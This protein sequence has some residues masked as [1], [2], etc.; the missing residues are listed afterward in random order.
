V[1]T[2]VVDLALPVALY[3]ALRAGGVDQLAALLVGGA[4]PA[5]RVAWV[6]A[7]TRHLDTIGAL[8]LAA[9]VLAVVS[10]LIEGDPRTLLVRNALLGFPFAVWMLASLAASRPLTYLSAKALLPSKER[11]FERVWSAEPAFR[12]V[13]RQ[14]TVLWGCTLLLQSAASVVMAYTLAIDSVPGLEAA[15]AVAVFVVLQIITQT[16]LHR[17]GA[18]R[19]VFAPL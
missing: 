6:L 18:M 15:V 10:S 19:K 8:V 9:V 7:R 14:L 13:W 12:R 1:V 4:P 3:Y 11:A 16:A 2:L 5:L 17:T